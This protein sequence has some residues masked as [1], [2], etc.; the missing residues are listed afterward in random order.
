MIPP[1]QSSLVGNKLFIF[2]GEDSARR[3][4]GDLTILDLPSM[5]WERT[6]SVAV[7]KP[8]KPQVQ[9]VCMYVC[10]CVSM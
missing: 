10:V 9:L 2:G 5:T 7:G 8:A 3:A 4:M 1:A 6:V